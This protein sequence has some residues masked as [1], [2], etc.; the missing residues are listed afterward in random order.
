MKNKPLRTVLFT[1]LAVLLTLSAAQTD[2]SRDTAPKLE[3][4]PVTVDS[5]TLAPSD[6]LPVD[7]ALKVGKLDNG[8]TYY[9]RQNTE[10]RN[11]AELALVIN[12]GSVLEDE[13]QRG[14]AHLLRAHA[15]QRH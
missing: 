10:P 5:T 11:R 15:L 8:L 1:L 9:L 6:P 12:A 14:L 13:D 3:L 4:N 7:P 2:T